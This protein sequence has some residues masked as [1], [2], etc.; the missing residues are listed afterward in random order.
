MPTKKEIKF[1]L[2]AHF[3]QLGCDWKSSGSKRDN[4][5]QTIT[6]G[7]KYN[8]KSLKFANALTGSRWLRV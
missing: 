4:N 1:I 2:I 6:E 8:T 7:Y 5:L 3:P